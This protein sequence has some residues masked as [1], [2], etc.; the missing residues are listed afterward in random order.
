[1]KLRNTF[2]F[3]HKKALETGHFPTIFKESNTLVLRKPKKPDYSKP[4]AYRPIALECTIGKVLE[5]IIAETISYLTETYELLP[6]NHFGGRPCRSTEDAMMLLVEN[7][8]DA[9]GIQGSILG[10]IH[11]RC[12]SIQEAKRCK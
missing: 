5:S 10:C 1:M 4:N 11:G 8:Y 6:A 12:G 3:S 7:I 9:W 2:F